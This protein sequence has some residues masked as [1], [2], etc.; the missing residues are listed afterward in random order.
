[1]DRPTI[2]AAVEGFCAAPDAEGADAL[3]ELLLAACEGLDKDIRLT[4]A[5][6]DVVRT[7]ELASLDEDMLLLLGA[8][9]HAL[10][11]GDWFKGTYSVGA[12]LTAAPRW[13][14]LAEKLLPTFIEAD[15]S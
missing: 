2:I 14:E 7:A 6:L 12:F 15:L 10:R 4:R 9:R 1:M 11:A 3:V 8:V 13:P 5:Q